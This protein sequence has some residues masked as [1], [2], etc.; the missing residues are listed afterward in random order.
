MSRLHPPTQDGAPS[1]VATCNLWLQ[2]AFPATSAGSLAKRPRKDW[3]LEIPCRI[4]HLVESRA[5]RLDHF[6]QLPD[7]LLEVF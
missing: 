5:Y 7:V 3:L 1:K 6:L 4:G 2:Q